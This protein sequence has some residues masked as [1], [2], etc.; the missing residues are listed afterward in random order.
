MSDNSAARAAEG[1]QV[2][3]RD[4]AGNPCDENGQ[5]VQ[6]G[7]GLDDMN[8]DEVYAEA[9]RLEVDGRS[10]MNKDE[11]IAAVRSANQAQQGSQPPQTADG[12]VSQPAVVA[13]EGDAAAEAAADEESRRMAEASQQAALDKANAQP[14]PDPNGTDAQPGQQEDNRTDA[15]RQ[16]AAGEAIGPDGPVEDGRN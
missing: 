1:E 2:E 7:D 10:D 13:N 5:P 14:A 16:Q 6:Q 11:L 4:A 9:Q 12:G 3:R 8:K 15:E